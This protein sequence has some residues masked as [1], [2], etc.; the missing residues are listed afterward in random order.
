MTRPVRRA[1]GAEA[2]ILALSVDRAL[3]I[4]LSAQ[5]AAQIRSFVLSGRVVPG[6][7]LP[8]T[9]ALAVELGIARATAVLAAEQLVAEGYVEGRAGAGL[10]VSRRLPDQP[11]QDR[12]VHGAEP[13]RP[14]PSGAAKPA[15]WGPFAVGA[16]DPE[17]FPHEGW[18][19]LL[20][21]GWRAHGP[22]MLRRVEPFGWPPLRAAIAHHLRDW[23][24][25]DC[26]AAQI[27]V[28]SGIAD[29]IGLIAACAFRPGDRVV[30]EDPGY[31]AIRVELARHGLRAVP[32]R[33]DAAGLDAAR[34]SADPVARKARGAFV[35]P[36]RQHPLGGAMP[37]DRRLAL[38]NWAAEAGGLVVED[39]FDGEYRYAGAPLPAL[40]S[41]DRDGRVVHVGSFSKVLSGSLRLG[42]VV[43]PHGLLGAAHAALGTRPPAASIIAQPAL[44][45]FLASGDFAAHVRRTRRIYARRLA[46]LLEAGRSWSDCIAIEPTEGGLHVVARF[47]PRMARDVTDR[48]VAAAAR[49]AGVV[50][51]PLSASYARAPRGRGLL[52]GFAGFPEDALIAAM[53]R[54]GGVVQRL[55]A[56]SRHVPA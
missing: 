56:G 41:L 23:R 17:L 25:I 21:R 26:D 30:V 43:L 37:V 27:V 49:D 52:L 1:K 44:A 34:I 24:A 2:A 10:F 19:R 11:F 48:A 8:S 22:E 3:S 12:T 29:A 36:A 31:P 35:T 47:G 33:V 55:S 50:V 5:I 53:D 4:P 14:L 16:I 39:E 7:R 28:T 6:A 42:Y 38:L 40:T 51:A 32:L 9:R 15:P 45:E 18:A 20:Q 46:A 54:L 13:R